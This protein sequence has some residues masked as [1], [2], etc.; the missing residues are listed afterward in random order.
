MDRDTPE[1]LNMDSFRSGLDTYRSG[2]DSNTVGNNFEKSYAKLYRLRA[3]ISDCIFT[4][5]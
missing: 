2:P 4:E 1:C 3:L 5:F